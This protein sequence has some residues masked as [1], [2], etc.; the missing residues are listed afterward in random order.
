VGL[1]AVSDDRAGWLRQLR[2]SIRVDPEIPPGV[3]VLESG[4]ERVARTASHPGGLVTEALAEDLRS[5]AESF[6]YIVRISDR[7]EPIRCECCGTLVALMP[8]A[9]TAEAPPW[10]PK[11]WSPAI[12]EHETLRRHT[13]RRCEW[14]R[15]SCASG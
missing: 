15:G 1:E 12:W 10:S 8:E 11:S 14:R 2:D 6:P 13:Q 5:F 4:G 3:I 7:G 9:R